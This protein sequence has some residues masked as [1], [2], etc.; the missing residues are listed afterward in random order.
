MHKFL[1]L[2]LCFVAVTGFSSRSIHARQI[3]LGVEAFAIE[4]Q[5][6][7]ITQALQ[8]ALEPLFAEKGIQIEQYSVTDLE[9]AVL[10]GRVDIALSSAGLPGRHPALLTP[11]AVAMLPGADNPNRSEGSL[12]IVH[13]KSHATTLE[14][15]R[16]T[17]LTAN[18]KQSFSGFAVG[19]GE[20]AK[21]GNPETFFKS[22]SFVDKIDAAA[23]IIADV[24]SGRSDAGVLKR[25][26]LEQFLNRN[27]THRLRVKP[28]ARTDV[29]GC[30]ASTDLFPAQT[31]SV[32]SGLD[33]Q[34]IR[35]I[36]L[37]LLQMRPTS[38]GVVWTSVTER[39]QVDQLMQRL[40]EGPYLHLRQWTIER[41][42]TK[43]WPW[44]MLAVAALLG[45]LWHSRRTSRL[46]REKEQLLCNMFERD[47]E[48]REK[49]EIFQRSGTVSL[50][51]SM[52]AHELRQPLTAL[53]LYAD[54]LAMMMEN[55][56]TVTNQ[57]PT[58]VKGISRESERA[59]AIVENV[60]NYARNQI[61]TRTVEDVGAVLS[62]SLRIF[63]LSRD[64]KAIELDVELPD[65]RVLSR[66]NN[67]EMTTV[68]VNLLRNAKEALQAHPVKKIRVRLHCE[69]S[70]EQ[71]ACSKAV[72]EIA[73]S[74]YP[75]DAQL[76]QRMGNPQNSTK[77]DGLGLGLS[78]VSMI[79]EAHGGTVR[80]ECK[81]DPVYT[82]LS[83]SVELPLANT[84]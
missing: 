42:L 31:I 16:G 57:L 79:V 56:Q 19:M 2:L 1:V 50:M 33:A 43:A 44:L 10:A 20:I 74:G 18:F 32:A 40:R 80:F 17:R 65:T 34:T 22:V 14:D 83:V 69:A 76:L 84:P 28:L 6:D 3:C 4:N 68:F 23:D 63:G 75:L 51:S 62:E 9:Q 25:C 82:G 67:L 27:P 59:S 49:I 36:T 72:V 24:E 78:L 11:V 48:Q 30:L 37:Q 13:E 53:T 5:R 29:S 46:L 26:A 8:K 66:L 60:R 61:A 55:G 58:I 71:S 15:L 7:N 39:D 45:L 12:F 38:E 64:T 52:V 54:S 47:A 35:A 81:N 70:N 73:D 21:L 77:K 41:F